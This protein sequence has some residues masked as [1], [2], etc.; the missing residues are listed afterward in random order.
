[1]NFPK[2]HF[3]DLMTSEKQTKCLALSQQIKPMSVLVHGFWFLGFSFF[4]SHLVS[5]DMTVQPWVSLKIKYYPILQLLN[6]ITFFCLVCESSWQCWKILSQRGG[7]GGEARIHFCHNS[8]L[9]IE[10]KHLFQF[11][12]CYT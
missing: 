4:L 2:S 5:C 1:M 11:Q 7:G 8:F 3:K 10:N 6:F 9:L 12:S